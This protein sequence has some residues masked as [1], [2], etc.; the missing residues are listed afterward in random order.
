MFGAR[1]IIPEEV[2]MG[3]KPIHSFDLFDR[4]KIQIVSQ[5]KN[6]EL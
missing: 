6:A 5:V 4:S 3:K 1:S 2:R